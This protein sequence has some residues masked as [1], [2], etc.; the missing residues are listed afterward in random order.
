MSGIVAGAL[1]D[2][3]G[4]LTAG[5]LRGFAIRT[6]LGAIASISVAKLIPAI[7]A[8][9]AAGG[10]VSQNARRVP[11]FAIVDL[12]NDKVVR[13]LSTR[14]VYSIL[15]H[16]NR[17]RGRRPRSPKVLVLNEGE[18]MLSVK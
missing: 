4:A 16:P 1:D 6:G 2:L 3:L 12:H 9:L 14:K 18:R 13:T 5:G 10:Q 8:D 17:T 15:T 11:Q 7:Q